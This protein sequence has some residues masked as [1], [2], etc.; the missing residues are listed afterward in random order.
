VLRRARTLLGG[1]D[2][3]HVQ[4]R[5]FTPASGKLAEFFHARDDSPLTMG[6]RIWEPG[7]AGLGR[8]PADPGR[9]FAHPGRCSGL[10]QEP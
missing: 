10:P 8:V 5:S 6:Q 4:M 3:G 9:W 2:L 7:P 1:L